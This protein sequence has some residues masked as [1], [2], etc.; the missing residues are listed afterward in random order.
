VGVSVALVIQHAVRMRHIAICDLPP[1]QYFSTVS[2]KR[3]GLK[4]KVTENKI[5]F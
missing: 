5:V 3:H 4:K 2:H 1:L